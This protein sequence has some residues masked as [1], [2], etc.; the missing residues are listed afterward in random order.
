M[1]DTGVAIGF[2]ALG[3]LAVGAALGI[4]ITQNLLHAVLFLVL[5]FVALAGLFLTLTADFVAVA[6]VLIYAGAVGV[7]IIFAVMLTP[8]SSRVNADTAFFGPGFV[9]GGLITVVMGFVAFKTPWNEASDGGFDTTVAAIGDALTNR[10][11][12]PFEIA[13][14]LLI[15]AMIGAIVLVRAAD[16]VERPVADEPVP[17]IPENQIGESDGRALVASTPRQSEPS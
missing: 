9:L 10:W 8:A 13:S 17:E 14:V 1:T 2:W 11:A 12:L 15:A 3:A 16:P 7:L 4:L 5:S 6:Q